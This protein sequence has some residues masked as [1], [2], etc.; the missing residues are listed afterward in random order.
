MTTKKITLIHASRDISS[1]DR[2]ENVHIITLK[3][4]TQIESEIIMY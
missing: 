2:V 1:Y 4:I 3:P